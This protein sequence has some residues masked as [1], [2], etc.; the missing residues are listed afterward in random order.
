[1]LN[2][3]VWCNGKEMFHF[4]ACDNDTYFPVW[5]V[6]FFLMEESGSGQ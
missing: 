4:I 3:K 6:V 1:M 2:Q 5:R